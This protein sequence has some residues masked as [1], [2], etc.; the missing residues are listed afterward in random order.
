MELAMIK[1]AILSRE[2]ADE[3][4]GHIMA[5]SINLPLKLPPEVRASQDL[6]QFCLSPRPVDLLY[7]IVALRNNALFLK[8]KDFPILVPDRR[9]LHCALLNRFA[10]N[11]SDSTD[12][13]E[14][15]TSS[16][17]DIVWVYHLLRRAAVLS[18]H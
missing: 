18:P 16:I 5:H 14:H 6:N 7:Q 10:F 4:I 12:S 11:V 1:D 3:L 17:R 2:A 13:Y 15:S 8:A 9:E